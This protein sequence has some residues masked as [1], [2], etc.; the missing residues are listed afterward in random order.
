MKF[1]SIVSILFFLLGVNLNAQQSR[2]ASNPEYR[3]FDFWIGE[4]EVKNPNNVVVGNS[5]IELTV[6]DCVILENWSGSSGYSGKSL[7][8]YSVID[9]KWHQKW[10]G[11]GGIPIE[12]SGEYNSET[13]SMNYTGE[14]FGQGGVKLDYKLTFYHLSDNHIRQHWEQSNDKG[15]TWVTIFDGHY[16]KKAE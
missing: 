4:W 2:C 12:F 16:R 6:G 9:Q 3:Q 15:T 10:I 11:S 8:Y 1:L 7:N 13:K 5:R 14:G